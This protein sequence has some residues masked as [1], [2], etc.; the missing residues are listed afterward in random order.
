MSTILDEIVAYK[1]T[2][3]ETC[4]ARRPLESLKEACVTLG[5]P[6]SFFEAL[7]EGD[8]IAVIA[9]VKKASPS[10]GIIR[11]DFDPVD[12]ARTYERNG[13]S[14][15]SVLTDEKYFQGSDAYLT[16]VSRA[17]GIPVLRK[18]F[19]IDP[20]Q[21]YEAK[22]I[23]ASAVLLIVSA[24]S[25]EVL[26]RLFEISKELMLDVLV[27]VHTQEELFLA[28][29]IGADIVGVNNRDLRTFE[30]DLQTT[31][32][33]LESVP[34]DRVIVSESGISNRDEIVRLRDA[35]V[36]AVLVGERLMREI[37]IGRSLRKLLGR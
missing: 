18:D 32:G 1:K 24:L 35:G 17:I 20:Y 5:D 29:D 33:L 28:L 31:F 34:D 14:A 9:E 11:D 30:T 16:D 37:D 3:V 4:R 25:P 7:I 22:C 19:V 6:P 13:A 23:G 27:E 21:I 26:G 12:I 8:D 15:I 36:D 2:F 10:K